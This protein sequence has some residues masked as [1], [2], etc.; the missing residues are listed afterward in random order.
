MNVKIIFLIQQDSFANQ[1]KEIM[2]Q[3]FGATFLYIIDKEYEL[4][5]LEE[6]CK[7]EMLNK[8]IIFQGQKTIFVKI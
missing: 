1:I 2:T 5:D 6:N 8:D 7:P 4:Y 3:K